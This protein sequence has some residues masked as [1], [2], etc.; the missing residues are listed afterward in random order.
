MTAGW[1]VALILFCLL[2]VIGG[3]AAWFFWKITFR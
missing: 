2:A 3:F 1:I